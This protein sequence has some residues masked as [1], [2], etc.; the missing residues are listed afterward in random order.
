MKQLGPTEISL[1][2]QMLKEGIPVAFPTETVY[3]LGARV[4]DPGAVERIFQMKGRPSDNPLICHI[5]NLDQL[6]LLAVE[7]PPVAVKLAHHF[8]PGPLTLILK[9]RLSVS[10]RVSGGHE[11][12]AVRMPR[13]CL[14][15]ELI[16]QAGEP[17]V[18]PSANKS[19]RPSSTKAEHVLT[20]FK[21][22]EGAVLDGGPTEGGLESTVLSLVGVE[23]LLL[24][25]GPITR[26][27]IAQVLQAPLPISKAKELSASPGTRYRHYAPRAKIW[28]VSSFEEA[29]SRGEKAFLMSTEKH[30]SFHHITGASF[31]ALLREADQKGYEEIVIVYKDVKDEALKDR[32]FRAAG[33]ST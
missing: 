26:E 5:A 16:Q 11:T 18:A 27:A 4:F 8:W 23:P 10:Y 14:A 24:R 33:Q 22:M 1:A 20:D 25:P 30:V 3:G 2:A 12:V 29:L 28:M 21:E 9:K 17:L 19:G 31:Y 15:L 32:L 13:H 7:V 6:E